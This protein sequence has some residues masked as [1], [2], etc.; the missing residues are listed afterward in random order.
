MSLW[1]GFRL[2]TRHERMVIH[3]K[4]H[5]HGHVSHLL[6]YRSGFLCTLRLT[7]LCTNAKNMLLY[8]D[9]ISDDEICSDAFPMCVSFQ[10]TT[11]YYH[12]NNSQSKLVDNIVYEV[13]CQTITVKEGDV[14]I[15][16]FVLSLSS[17]ELVILSRKVPIPLLRSRR[18]LW[19]RV[20]QQ[21]TM[22]C[23]RSAYNKPHSTKSRI[24]VISRL[25]SLSTPG[26]YV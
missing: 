4:G 18:N 16:L 25:Y 20:L 15:G 8:S 6:F 9:I 12:A 19:R 3:P 2:F 26:S 21:S 7:A 1:D 13:D 22:L 11:Y 10:F 14:D 23:T 24:S 5:D 17:T